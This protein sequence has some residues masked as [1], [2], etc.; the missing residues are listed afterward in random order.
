MI[1]L[2][3]HPSRATR[4]TGSSNRDEN[5]IELVSSHLIVP[6]EPMV[7][8]SIDERL[9]KGSCERAAAIDYRRARE[10]YACDTP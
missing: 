10:A 9:R 5:I 2:T 6:L 8:N 3:A 4:R 1:V 7:W